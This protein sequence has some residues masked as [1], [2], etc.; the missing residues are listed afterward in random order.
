MYFANGCKWLINSDTKEVIYEKINTNDCD[1]A[2]ESICC[3]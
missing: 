1:A 2:G 3:C